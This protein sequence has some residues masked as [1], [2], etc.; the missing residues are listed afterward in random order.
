MNIRSVHRSVKKKCSFFSKVRSRHIVHLFC[1]KLF[2]MLEL[3]LCLLFIRLKRL[4]IVSVDLEGLQLILNILFSHWVLSVCKLYN[5]YSFCFV[6][7]FMVSRHM[8]ITHKC[9]LTKTQKSIYYI[10]WNTQ[11]NIY[12]PLETHTY[13]VWR[14]TNI[15]LQND[16]VLLENVCNSLRWKIQQNPSINKKFEKTV[17]TILEV[18]LLLIQRV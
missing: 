12:K 13:H 8:N 1:M 18:S 17:G 5:W 11:H 10:Q 9:Y 2:R 3:F 4:V 14:T 6:E 7:R 16:Y 15:W